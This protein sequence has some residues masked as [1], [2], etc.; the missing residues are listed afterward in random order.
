MTAASPEGS[1]PSTVDP[2]APYAGFEGTVGKIFST[3][4]PHLAGAVD[5]AGRIAQRDRDDG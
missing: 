5:P 4:E 2:T 1:A 3:S